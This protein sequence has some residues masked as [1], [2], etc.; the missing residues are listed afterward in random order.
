MP[1]VRLKTPLMFREL[2]FLLLFRGFNGWCRAPSS[3]PHEVMHLR[4]QI[5]ITLHAFSSTFTFCACGAR[6]R[7]CVLTE[8]AAFVDEQ[9]HFTYLSQQTE[10]SNHAHTTS[11]RI[12]KGRD[13]DLGSLVGST[14]GFGPRSGRR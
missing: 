7:D 11:G 13:I 10:E 4:N 6:A 14:G 2:F 5:A 9:E 12:R 8:M 3:P 1:P